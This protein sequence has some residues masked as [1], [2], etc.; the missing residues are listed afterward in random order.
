MITTIH[1]EGVYVT[2]KGQVR[3]LRFVDQPNTINIEN[4]ESGVFLELSSHKPYSHKEIHNIIDNH[5]RKMKIHYILFYILYFFVE[6]YRHRVGI[7]YEPSL[8]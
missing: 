6:S 5:Y 7:Q 3:F 8:H 1:F 2:W 4:I